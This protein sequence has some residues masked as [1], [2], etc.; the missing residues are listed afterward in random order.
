MADTITNFLD[1]NQHKTYKLNMETN[2]I[3]GKCDG[4]EALKMTIYCTLGIA[5]DKYPIYSFE[6]G[7][8]LGELIGEPVQ[9]ALAK[10][11]TYVKEALLQ[12]D[13]ISEV[14]DFDFEVKGH[15]VSVSF[16]VVSK[17]GDIITESEV[18]I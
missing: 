5:K 11:E 16:T 10:I 8:Q 4:L 6:Y 17:Y 14:T 13:R 9:F 7:S 12:D 2:R 3:V 15:N 18:T 1:P